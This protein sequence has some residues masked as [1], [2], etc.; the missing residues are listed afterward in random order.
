MLF[1][2]NWYANYNCIICWVDVILYILFPLTTKLVWS[3]IWDTNAEKKLSPKLHKTLHIDI[4]HCTKALESKNTASKNK[5]IKL[6]SFVLVVVISNLVI[7]ALS[8]KGKE[9]EIKKPKKTFETL[10]EQSEKMFSNTKCRLT[11][12]YPYHNS[13]LQLCYRS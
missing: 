5:K 1:D 6:I 11:I 10:S 8:S 3:R 13:L 7:V 12:S 9:K 4:P 2:I